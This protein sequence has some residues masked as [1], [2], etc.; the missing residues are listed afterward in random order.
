MSKEKYPYKGLESLTQEDKINIILNQVIIIRAEL[1]TIK[2]F[3]Y[4][5]QSQID[6]KT[7]ALQRTSG[8]LKVWDEILRSLNPNLS[9][10]ENE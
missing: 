2:R 10:K 6:D 8:Q 9:E 5:N 1:D 3:V 7:L 4:A